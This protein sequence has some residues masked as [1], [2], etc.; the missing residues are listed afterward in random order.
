MA[1][2]TDKT[3]WNAKAEAHRIHSDLTGLVARFEANDLD[4]GP[5][6]KAAKALADVADEVQK[7]LDKQFQE[8]AKYHQSVG[9][10]PG[11]IEQLQRENEELKKRLAASAR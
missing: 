4:S 3:R 9:P 2:P 10:Q 5:V 8:K 7:V 1:N 11:V 6:K